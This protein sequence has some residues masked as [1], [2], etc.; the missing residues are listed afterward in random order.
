[1]TKQLTIDEMLSVLH[2]MGHPVANFVRQ[3]VE[4]LADQMAETISEAL[5]VE[6]GSAS[7]EMDC[8]GTCV[9][10]YAK[11]V[12]Q[13]CPEPMRDF[14]STEWTLEEDRTPLDPETGAPF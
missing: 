12:G 2:N 13:P 3:S 7:Y 11:K 1:M 10:F 8:G 14:D 9:P 5:D 4:R 6:C